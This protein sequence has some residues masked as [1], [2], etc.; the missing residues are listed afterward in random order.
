[1]DCAPTCTRPMV[2]TSVPRNQNQP[3]ARKGFCAGRDKPTAPSRPA[4]AAPRPARARPAS[5]ADGNRR[6]RDPAART[7]WRCS[8]HR[9]ARRWPGACPAR[10]PHRPA[11][12]LDEK[13]HRAARRREDEE[14]N[15]FNSSERFQLSCKFRNPNSTCN[16]KSATC[17]AARNPAAATR[18][19]A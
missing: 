18:T 12:F 7:V 14:R 13:S 19:A 15:F 5:V 3:T 1:M 10:R 9:R 6:W 2:G 11:A 8:A 16:L 4:A 17:P